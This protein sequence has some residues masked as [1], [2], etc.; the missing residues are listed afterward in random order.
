MIPYEY[1]KKKVTKNYESKR[2]SSETEAL[3]R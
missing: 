1:E 2:I 3:P